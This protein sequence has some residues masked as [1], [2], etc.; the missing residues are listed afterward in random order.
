[1]YACNVLIGVWVFICLCVCVCMSGCFCARVHE[2]GNDGMTKTCTDDDHDDDA[3][4]DV[5][6]CM[7]A[8][9]TF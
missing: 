8:C 3:S 9:V 2:C 4:D 7:L 6:V 1:M 5:R